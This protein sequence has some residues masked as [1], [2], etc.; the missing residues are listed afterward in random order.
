VE[1]KPGGFVAYTKVFGKHNTVYV[2]FTDNGEGTEP[3]FETEVT[4]SHDGDAFEGKLMAAVGALV[5][6]A[7]RE[8]IDGVFAAGAE[9]F[10]FPEKTFEKLDNFFLGVAEDVFCHCSLL[11]FFYRYYRKNVVRVVQKWLESCYGGNFFL[12][13]TLFQQ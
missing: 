7:T 4:F 1:K 9:D 2:S 3:G 5:E 6:R 13:I 12:A 8:A 10:L 11:C